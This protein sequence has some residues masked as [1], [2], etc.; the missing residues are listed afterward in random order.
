MQVRCPSSY[1][2]VN[3]FTHTSSKVSAAY[4]TL[5]MLGALD[6][7]RQLTPIG[8]QMNNFPLEPPYARALLASVK[9]ACTQEVLAII[10]VLSSSSKLFFDTSDGDQREAAYEARTKFRHSSGDHMTALAAFRAYEGLVVE[11]ESRGAR[12]EWCRK[13]FVN[14]RTLSEA[15]D[16]QKQLRGICDKQ[17]IDWRVSC[18]ADFE[19][20]LKSLLD[21]LAQHV[22]LLK[23]GSY[24]QVIGSGVCSHSYISVKFRQLTH[25][26]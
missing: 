26:L 16:I 17:K 8:R 23:A 15:I 14:E 10:S 1:D 12:K 11:D 22:A 9:Y 4:K 19:R 24:K 5:F 2:P 18:G 13:H 3:V 21:G 20:V 7:N 25:F 6:S